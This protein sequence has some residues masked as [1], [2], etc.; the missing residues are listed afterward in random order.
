[1]LLLRTDKYQLTTNQLKTRTW[2]SEAVQQRQY[3]IRPW[4]VKRWLIT[5]SPTDYTLQTKLLL[6]GWHHMAHRMIEAYKTLHYPLT[7]HSLSHVTWD[8]FLDQ[9]YT[10]MPSRLTQL[11]RAAICKL[12]HHNLMS[13]SST[14]FTNSWHYLHATSI[15]CT[16]HRADLRCQASLQSD[17]YTAG[18]HRNQWMTIRWLHVHTLPVLT[19]THAATA[20]K[21][22]SYQLY[23]S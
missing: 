14:K 16:L 1:M 20:K 18:Y 7:I 23:I 5:W 22:L 6:I 15:P 10:L 2:L 21:R 12:K 13:A 9:R 19:W 3:M 4:T 11:V 8:T 17:R